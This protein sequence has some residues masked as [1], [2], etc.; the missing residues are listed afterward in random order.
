MTSAL[1]CLEPHCRGC[2]KARR[3]T[4]AGHGWQTWGSDTVA[5]LNG[6]FALAVWDRRDRVLHLARDP[7]GVKPLYFV[8]RQRRFAFA[9]DVRALLLLPWVSRDI[10]VEE[11]AEYLSF[12]YV[13]APRTLLRDIQLLPAGHIARVD[14]TGVRLHRWW[15]PESS[16]PG[17]E[18]EPEAE[19]A[20]A[21]KEA[22]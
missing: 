19:P 6:D 16:P 3:T 13:H 10:A 20:G 2:R 12:R 5:R 11:L 9:S 1:L 14:G 18:P 17:A 15:L 21:G 7:A 8:W 4:M 22:P